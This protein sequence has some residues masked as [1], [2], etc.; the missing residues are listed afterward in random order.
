[1]SGGGRTEARSSRR[2]ARSR[3]EWVTF[4]FASAVLAMVIGV[5]VSLWASGP[6]DPPAFETR[7]VSVRQVAGRFHVRAVVENTG[8]ETAQSVQL[9]AELSADGEPPQEAEQTIDFLSGGDE[10]EVELIFTTDPEEGD[11]EILVRSFTAR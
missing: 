5:I 10:E 4:A 11:L 7:T 3:A 2:A 9:S 6:P 1:M 8:D